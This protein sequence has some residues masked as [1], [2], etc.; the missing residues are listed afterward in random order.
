MPVEINE[1]QPR[2]N[3][4]GL[5]TYTSGRH[6]LAVLADTQRQAGEQESSVKGRKWEASVIP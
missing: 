5:C 4:Q 1:E 3:N 6:P 2:E